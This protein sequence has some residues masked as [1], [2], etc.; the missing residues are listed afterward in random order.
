MRHRM[1]DPFG[2]K[3]DRVAAFLTLSFD[4][5][6]GLLR[7]VRTVKP[8]MGIWTQP[9]SHLSETDLQFRPGYC[10]CHLAF[11]PNLG[12]NSFKWPPVSAI[13]AHRYMDKL[14]SQHR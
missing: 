10:G 14:M 1:I 5:P 11:K 2:G 4:K 3:P 6:G 8:R 9:F 13:S 7:P 12:S